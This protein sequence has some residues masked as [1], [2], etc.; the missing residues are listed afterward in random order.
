MPRVATSKR[1]RE[2]YTAYLTR[3]KEEEERAKQAEK[4]KPKQA[5]QTEQAQTESEYDSLYFKKS[6]KTFNF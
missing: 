4:T 6:A 1:L 5:E 2:A 3:K